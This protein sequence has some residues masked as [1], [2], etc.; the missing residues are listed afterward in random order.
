MKT[1]RSNLPSDK[2]LAQISLKRLRPRAQRR[3][4]R[5][6][7]VAFLRR[8]LRARRIMM[9]AKRTL[10]VMFIGF[11]VCSGICTDARCSAS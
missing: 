8:F 4:E 1:I 7:L 3:L 9:S 10:T 2:R 11:V 6:S 5:F